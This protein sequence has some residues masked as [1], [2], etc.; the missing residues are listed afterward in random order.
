MKYFFNTIIFG[1]LLFSFS[2]VLYAQGNGQTTKGA[3]L[4]G[5]VPV[6]KEILKVKLPVSQEKK[7]TNGLQVILIENNKVPTFTMQMVVLGGG[8]NEP[9][10]KR[11]VAALTSTLLREGTKNRTS[12]QISEKI[13][14]LGAVYFASVNAFGFTT[15]LSLNGFV[16]DFDPLLEI[17]GDM[18]LNP[19]FLP[20]EFEKQKATTISTNQ[21]LRSVP[22][23]L[24]TERLRKTLYGNHPAAISIHSP[25]TLKNIIVQD[26]VNFHKT[27]YHPN[28]AFIVINGNFKL[29]ELLPKIERVFGNWQKTNAPSMTIAEV[30][31]IEKSGI[32]LINRPGSV[33]TTLL[34]GTLGIKRTDP[35]YYPL[36]VMNEIFGGSPASRLFMNLREDKGF[37]YGVSSSITPSIYP[38]VIN[39]NMSVRTDVTE[40]ALSELMKEISRLQ[41]E[42]VSSTELENAK[43]SLVGSFALSTE[44]PQTL[45]TNAVQQKL[46]N[47]PANYWD[48]Y[49]QYVE[50]VTANDVQR[51]ARKYLSPARLQIVAVGDESKIKDS[52]SKFGQLQLFDADGKP[53][54]V[55]STTINLQLKPATIN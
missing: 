13:D 12:R 10:D 31:A 53:I 33:Q 23:V 43:R 42:S 2:I 4:K 18:T 35:D 36:L 39:T 15:N 16:E 37:T 21:S 6:N 25:E 52:L 34:V 26:V 20:E 28:N 40:A 51:V 17:F 55:T 7:L 11:G 45:I 8:I 9:S 29:N 19:S 24:A 5:K 48:T 38:G 44:Q 14:E 47:F 41:N 3:V 54:A 46:Y 22:T 27:F 32:Y 30:P 1:S 50:T 49:P